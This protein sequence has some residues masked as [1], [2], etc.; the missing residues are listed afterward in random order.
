MHHREFVRSQISG[1][2]KALRGFSFRVNAPFPTDLGTCGRLVHLSIVSDTTRQKFG[3]SERRLLVVQLRIV[4]QTESEVDRTHAKIH[5]ALQK[6]NLDLDFESASLEPDFL[7]EPLAVLTVNYEI[8]LD[9]HSKA[10]T[11]E[12]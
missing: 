10:L 8:E 4:D 11:L 7:Q 5:Q 3:G 1:A 9:I 12:N 2:I 6:S